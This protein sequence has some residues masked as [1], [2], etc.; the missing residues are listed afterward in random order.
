MSP[1]PRPSAVRAILA[2]GIVAGTL[3]IVFAI[4]FYGIARGGTAADVLRSV[5]SGWLG[6]SALTG[7]AAWRPWG[8]PRS[9]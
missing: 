1:D 3:D 6:K 4:F 7:E 9:T 5:A 8:S 2:G